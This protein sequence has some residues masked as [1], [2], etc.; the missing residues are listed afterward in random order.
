[1]EKNPL[2]SVVTPCHNSAAFIHRLFD[3]L[4]NQTYPRIE[5]ITVDNDSKDNTAEVIQNYIPKFAAKGYSLTYIHEG[6]LGPSTGVQNGIRHIK[7]DYLVMPDSDDWYAHEKSIETFIRKFQELPDN[8]AIIRSQLQ[9]INEE[10]LQPLG[11]AYESFPEDDPGTLFEDCLFAKNGYNFAP[12]DY[13]VKVSKFR[14]MTNM[15]FYNAYNMGQQR[16]ICLPL[17]YKY[18]AW[19]I[20]E[21]LVCYLVRSNSVSHGDYAKYHVK[22]ELYK[23]APEYIDSIFSTIDTMPESQKQNYRKAYLRMRAEA[24]LN[25][26]M[27]NGKNKD[28]HLYLKDYKTNGGAAIWLFLNTYRNVL[29]YRAKRTIKRIVNKLQNYG[30]DY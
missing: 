11:L 2:V 12:I 5:M 3:S 10:N 18:K 23:K 9:F 15:E 20:A 26:A 17:Y 27:I 13:M 29:L 19:T 6:D 16:Q 14:E 22:K 21:P 24:L 1:M 7:G 25:L 28:Y 4:L 8:Y 30:L